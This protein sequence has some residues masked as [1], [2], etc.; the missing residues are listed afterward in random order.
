MKKYSS[1]ELI[2]AL[3]K[4][5]IGPGD[6]VLVHSA[7]FALG[8][9]EP[10]RGHDTVFSLVQTIIDYLGSEGTLV[11]PTFNFDFC[12]GMAFDRWQT[13][14]KNMGVLSEAIRTWPRA[15]RSCHPMQSVAAVGRLA[16]K[17]CKPDT[18]S[19]FAPGGPF[20]VMLKA[21]AKLLFLGATIQAASMIHYAE[22]KLKVPYRYWKKFSGQ[23]KDRQNTQL[24][25]YQMFVRKLEWA[26]ELDLGPLG[27]AM[28]VR[29]KLF[30]SSLG[31]GK[32]SSCSF[33]DFH[34]IS[35]EMIRKDPFCLLKNKDA[36]LLKSQQNP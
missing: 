13:P 9:F 4:V 16:G 31:M 6:T 23:Y 36:V 27:D 10:L 30:E 26:P 19:S 25:E 24:R 7:L 32:I 8:M 29:Q 11:A 2:S 21:D 1:A 18:F 17:I 5:K 33:R 14:S 3:K 28:A 12:T 20:E 34:E 22:E 15:M 35:A